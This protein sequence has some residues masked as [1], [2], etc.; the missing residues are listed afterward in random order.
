MDFKELAENLGLEEEEFVEIVELFVEK[1]ASEL[2]ELQGAIDKSDIKEVIAIGHSIKGASGNLGF[3]EIAELA[4]AV[5]LKAR[6]GSLDGVTKDTKMIK[7]KFKHVQSS[8][9]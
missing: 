2:I 1:T 8:L 6:E 5:E 7:E 3:I 4:D 9:V